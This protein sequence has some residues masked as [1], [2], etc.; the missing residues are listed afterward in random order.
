MVQRRYICYLFLIYPSYA[1]HLCRFN[2]KLV[3]LSEIWPQMVLVRLLFMQWLFVVCT[4]AYQSK[5]FHV[6]ALDVIYQLLTTLPN[7]TMDTIVAATAALK[8]ISIH[9]GSEVGI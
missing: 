5:I 6:G 9:Q 4:E 7:H 3:L 8:N 2:V 1:H